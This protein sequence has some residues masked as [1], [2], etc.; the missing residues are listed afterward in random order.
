MQ[1][2]IVYACIFTPTSALNFGSTIEDPHC[3]IMQAELIGIICTIGK[4]FSLDEFRWAD[5]IHVHHVDNMEACITANRLQALMKDNK[6]NKT[7]V[8]QMLR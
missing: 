2:I 6:F 1:L 4:L 3:S 7:V 5:N 8:E